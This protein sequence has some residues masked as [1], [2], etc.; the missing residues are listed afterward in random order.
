MHIAIIQTCKSSLEFKNVTTASVYIALLVLASV[1]D[2]EMI[3]GKRFGLVK[4][5]DDVAYA[6]T[7]SLYIC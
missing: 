3:K 2:N 7:K 4:S 1:K 6:K 5:L